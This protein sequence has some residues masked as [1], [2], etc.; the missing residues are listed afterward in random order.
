MDNS[1][2]ENLRQLLA[3]FLDADSAR[4]AAEDIEKGDELLRAYPAPQPGE[5]VLAEVNR[6]VVEAVR[7]RRSIALRHKVLAVAGVAAAIVVLSAVALRFFAG[8]PVKQPSARYATVIPQRIWEGG[9]ITT[10][11]PD[12]AVLTAEVETIENELQALLADDDGS[13]NSVTVG[14]LEMELIEIGGDFWKG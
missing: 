1:G 12:I 13:N 10:D 8:Q 11:D 5:K 4:R 7:R 9:D 3:A 2:K 14:D 6:R